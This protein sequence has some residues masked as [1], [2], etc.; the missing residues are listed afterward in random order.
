MARRRLTVKHL[1]PWSVLKFSILANIAFTAI[2]LVGVMVVWTI[3][4]RLGIVE[5]ICGIAIDIGFTQCGLSTNNLFRAGLMIG[6]LWVVVQTAVMVFMAFLYNLIADLTGGLSLI[7]VDEAA[8]DPRRGGG[9]RATTGAVTGQG[10]RATAQTGSRARGNDTDTSTAAMPAVEGGGRSWRATRTGE[11]QAARGPGADP[12]ARA[13]RADSPPAPRRARPAS[14]APDD[15][16]GD[17]LFGS[18]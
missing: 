17:E 5:Q 9:G 4:E 3:I 14:A 12:T 2:V 18:R 11:D 6:M 10:E 1:D 13:G 16:D 8:P 15:D 7:A